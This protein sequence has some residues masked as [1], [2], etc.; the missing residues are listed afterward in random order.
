MRQPDEPAAD[1]AR[2]LAAL[3]SAGLDHV[4]T[5][6]HVSFRVGAGRDGLIDAATLLATGDLPVYVGLYLLALR[7]PVL[8]A[9]QLSTL[10]ESAP[11]RLVLGVGVGGEDRHEVEVCGVD[12]RTRG[13]R[14]DECLAVL[15]G[16]LAGDPVTHHGDFFDLEEALV[17]PA[18]SLPVPIVVGGRSDAALARAARFGDGWLGIWVSARRY[19]EVVSRIAELADAEGRGEVAWRHGLNVWCGLGADPTEGREHLAA[20]MTALY[21]L[22]FEAF[23]RWSPSGSPEDVAAFLAPYV[24][25]GVRDLNLICPG[26]D[27]AAVLTRVAEV[28]RL[29]LD[30]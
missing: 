13:R 6:D 20:A 30:R 15:R 23:A 2:D 9:R 18:P 12:P 16:L 7:H 5:A 24:D 21:G 3:S 1:L 25:A 19:A 27:R 14:T 11:G 22:P 4:V 26:R 8:V 10:A 17:L 28:R 29:L